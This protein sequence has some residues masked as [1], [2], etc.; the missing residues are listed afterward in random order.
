MSIAKLEWQR[1]KIFNQRP[2]LVLFVSKLL[3]QK[4]YLIQAVFNEIEAIFYMYFCLF[5]EIV[6]RCKKITRTV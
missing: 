3:N 4:T 1:L 6:L 2:I 5:E